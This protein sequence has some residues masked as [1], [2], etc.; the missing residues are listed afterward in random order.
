MQTYIL[1]LPVSEG[2][3][4]RHYGFDEEWFVSFAF[5]KAPDDA[6]APA[7]Q[8]TLAKDDIL[9]AVKVAAKTGISVCQGKLP[10]RKCRISLVESTAMLQPHGHFI[11]LRI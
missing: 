11:V 1:E 3:R 2:R 8:V 7:L 9:T 4:P 5:L 10:G 6:E